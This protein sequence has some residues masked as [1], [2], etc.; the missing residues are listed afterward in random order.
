[1]RAPKTLPVCI[2]CLVVC[3]P[4]SWA[5]AWAVGMRI[6]ASGSLPIGVWRESA[7]PSPHTALARGQVVTICPPDVD[8]FRIARHRGYIG[9]GW[10]PHGYQPLFK[11]IAAVAGDVVRVSSTG[12]EVN[13]VPVANSLPLR[14]DGTRQPLPE[15]AAGRYPVSNGYVWVIS[16]YNRRS[17]DSRYFGPV[18]VTN[19]RGVVIPLWVRGHV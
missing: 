10:C 9:N 11:P 4:L 8:A 18:R 19:I 3:I 6:N 12:I 16:S 15:L 14:A 1:M 17:F 13:G 2:R 7:I 5:I